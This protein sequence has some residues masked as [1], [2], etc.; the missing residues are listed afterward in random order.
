MGEVFRSLLNPNSKENCKTTIETTGMNSEEIFNQMSR[1]LN[2]I[3]SSLK[4]QILNAITT[5][6]TEKVLPFIQ[7]TLD[8][9]GRAYFTV[10][11][12]ESVGLQEGP[13]TSNFTVV[14]RSSRG[15]QRS[16]EVV[17]TQK[18]WENHP[19]TCF[20]RKIPDKRLEIVQ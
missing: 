5:A 12:R 2:E 18:I 20:T 4:S 16:P 3:K 11:N 13:R 14:D 6:I 10:V 9:Q 17:N 8:T 19:K 15:L 7:N 1:K